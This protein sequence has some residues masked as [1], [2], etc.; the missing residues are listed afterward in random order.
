MNIFIII[1]D[2]KQPESIKIKTKKKREK[3]RGASVSFDAQFN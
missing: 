1:K 3:T 2:M